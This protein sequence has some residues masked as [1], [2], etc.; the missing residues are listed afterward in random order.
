[1][2]Q[3]L[4]ALPGDGRQAVPVEGHTCFRHVGSGSHHQ[5]RALE[6]LGLVGAQ[7]SQDHLKLADRFLQGGGS[8]VY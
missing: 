8:Q 1:M 5:A 3:R 4:Q 6:E 7:L 2:D